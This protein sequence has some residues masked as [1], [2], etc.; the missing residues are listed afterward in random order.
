MIFESSAVLKYR[1]FSGWFKTHKW[2]EQQRLYGVITTTAHM[3]QMATDWTVT[4]ICLRQQR[5]LFNITFIHDDPG[6]TVLYQKTFTDSLPIFVDIIQYLS[7]ISSIYYSPR[8]PR[9][10][11]RY[12]SLCPQNLSRFSLVKNQG[13]GMGT[14]N[15]A[16]N[17]SI[18][19]LIWIY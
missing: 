5:H 6:E 1:R 11:V 14:G 9:S 18:F 17:S 8:H 15:T 2:I 10:V 3:L 4:D 19:S 12:D 13:T 7:L 16:K